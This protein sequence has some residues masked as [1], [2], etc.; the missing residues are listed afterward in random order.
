[1]ETLSDLILELVANVEASKDTFRLACRRHLQAPTGETI[2]TLNET[3]QKFTALKLELDT[4][5]TCLKKG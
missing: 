2:A 1:M 3:V 5:R 4:I